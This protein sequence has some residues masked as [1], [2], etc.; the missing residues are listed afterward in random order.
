MQYPPDFLR[1]Q[2]AFLTDGQ[3]DQQ[4]YMQALTN[5]QGD[6]WL[7]VEQ[8]LR[9]IL[10][11]QK[12]QNLIQNLPVVSESEIRETYIKTKVP[13]T[14]ESLLFPSSMTLN[15]SINIS[16]KAITTYYNKNKDDYFVNETREM[17]YVYFEIKPTH[18]DSVSRYELAVE[19][20]NR[21]KEGEAFETIAAE[22]TEDPSG[23][24]S[25]GD[26]GWFDEHQMVAPFSKA[27]FA[28]KKGEISEPVLTRFGYHI[29]K[30]ED[31]RVQNGNP[32][33]K[34]RHILLKVS[35]GPE[36]LDK[37]RSKAS[38][39]AFDASD[40]GFEE[41][42]DSH[43]V[44]IKS[45]GFINKENTYI[46]GFGPFKRA[47]Q[48]AFSDIPEGTVSELMNADNG[49]VIFKLS[50]VHPEYFKSLDDVRESIRTILI[51]EKRTE[52][53]GEIARQV[54]NDLKSGTDIESITKTYPEVKHDINENITLN[55]P[56]KGISR[57]NALIGTIMALDDGQ[58]SAPVKIGNQ[59][60]IVKKLNGGVIDE[61]DYA[62][63][64]E[65]L[66]EQMI[67]QAK[68]D[69]YNYWLA[70]LEKDAKIIDN[71]DNMY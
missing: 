45:T 37:I 41:A 38:L 27:A 8:Y 43:S 20:I 39:F 50:A 23:K 65:L 56:L 36:T 63:E 28:L 13:F 24:N 47:T 31:K 22:Y 26:L 59:F 55:R 16:D 18:E 40:I 5:P 57:S 6:E 4:K 32:Q 70:E 29:I 58:F 35:P 19:L 25:G 66:R 46:T 21:I 69:Y 1:N 15:D 33:V 54:Y 34:A 30:V 17:D 71:R 3:F 61:D 9:G 67:K 68:T 7:G 52:R 14:V 64:K 48:F 2:E 53:L 51:T 44:T 42:A 12:I 10:P 11:F 49:Y 62:V 60:V